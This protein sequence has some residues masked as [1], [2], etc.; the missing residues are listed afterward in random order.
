MSLTISFELYEWVIV[1][2]RCNG[3][4]YVFP[5]GAGFDNV[6]AAVQAAW[7]ADNRALALELARRYG[8]ENILCLCCARARS[9]GTRLCNTCHLEELAGRLTTLRSHV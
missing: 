9:A 6:R 8:M 4:E 7:L 2:L 3:T 1:N 5:D